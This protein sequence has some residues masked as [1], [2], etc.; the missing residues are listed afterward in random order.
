MACEF[1]VFML[2]ARHFDSPQ[3]TVHCMS[4]SIEPHFHQKVC[5]GPFSLHIYFPPFLEQTFFRL[6][7]YYF[8]K[9]CLMLTFE[10]EFIWTFCVSIWKIAPKQIISTHVGITFPRLLCTCKYGPI[11]TTSCQRMCD[12]FEKI[13]HVASKIITASTFWLL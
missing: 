3:C 4:H 7:N 11:S 13:I 10:Y 9:S 12:E 8:I 6:L 2:A 5:F 1:R